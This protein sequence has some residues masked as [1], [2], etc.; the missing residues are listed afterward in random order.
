[1]IYHEYSYIFSIPEVC[2]KAK[3]F[4]AENFGTVRQNKIDK[5]SWYS[6]YPKHFWYQ[7][8]SETQN[9]SPKNVFG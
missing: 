3:G 7:N 1:M 4:P 5:K 2:E 9:G 6:Q 8:P